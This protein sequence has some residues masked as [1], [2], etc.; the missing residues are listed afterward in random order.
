MGTRSRAC[1]HVG[2]GNDWVSAP[3]MGRAPGQ[4]RQH[5]GGGRTTGWHDEPRADTPE[6]RHN[7]LEPPRDRREEE[8]HP[9]YSEDDGWGREQTRELSSPSLIHRNSVTPDGYP[10]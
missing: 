6:P 5:V 3:A 8:K 7:R 9:G 1:L 4:G 2:R 10:T